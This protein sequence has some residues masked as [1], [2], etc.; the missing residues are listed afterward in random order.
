MGLLTIVVQMH[1]HS[2]IPDLTRIKR[3]ARAL[4][5]DNGS[6]TYMQYLDQAAR[7][8]YG[9]RHFHEAQAHYAQALFAQETAPTS[10]ENVPQASPLQYY[11]RSIQEYYLDF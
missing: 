8:I 1:N 7:E 9:V 5:R 6:M 2:S 10:T 3:K 11:L 4:K